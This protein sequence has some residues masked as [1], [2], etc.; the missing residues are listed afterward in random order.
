MFYEFSS[1]I[2]RKAG[3]A[4]SCHVNSQCDLQEL[5]S[6]GAAHNTV[7]SV[8]TSSLW[9]YIRFRRFPRL[10]C[11][12]SNTSIIF[13]YQNCMIYFV[14]DNNEI[15]LLHLDPVLCIRT[16]S[17][18]SLN[19]TATVTSGG[20]LMAEQHLLNSFVMKWKQLQVRPPVKICR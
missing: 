2:E 18:S 20:T 1:Y 17:N 19:L 4:I 9:R 7:A 10:T 11:V 8:I 14:I 12:I 16:L 6:N 5:E 13:M 15:L 3:A